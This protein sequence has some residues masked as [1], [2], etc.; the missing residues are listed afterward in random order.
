MHDFSFK[1]TKFSASQRTHSPQTP[2][3][4]CKRAIDLDAPPTH[5]PMSKTDVRPCV[6]W[7]N[8]CCKMFGRQ[9]Q[10]LVAMIF[11]S[12]FLYINY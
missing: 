5:P 11:F 1:N 8:S 10:S 4:V 12:H 9:E 7:C 2:L 6:V 3:C